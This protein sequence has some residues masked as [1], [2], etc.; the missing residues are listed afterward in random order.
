MTQRITLLCFTILMASIVSQAQ[1][2]KF[3]FSNIQSELLT[4]ANAVVRLDKT[5]IDQSNRQ[6]IICHKHFAITALNKAG[7][8]LLLFNESYKEG[9]DKI[10]DIKIKIYDATGALIRTIKKNEIKDLAAYDGFSMITDSRSKVFEIELSTFPVTMEWAFT[11][12]SKNTIGVEPW[13]PIL[14]Y[15]VSVEESTYKNTNTTNN[16]IE[17]NLSEYPTIT[18]GNGNYAAKNLT[19][20]KREPYSPAFSEFAPYVLFNP[21]EFIYEGYTGA[22]SSWEELGKWTYKNYLMDRNNL[23]A[24]EV[25]PDI[26]KIINGET[27]PE[28][29]AR[30]IY[31]YVQE[32]TRYINISLN[33]GGVRPMKSQDVH[34]KKYGDCKA[35]SFYMK[36]LL[37]LY[38]IEANY[39]EVYA[40][41]T[42]PKSLIPEFCSASQGNHII[43]NIP[44]QQDT[45][46]VD[47]TS[48]ELPFNFLGTFTDNRNALI[49]NENGGSLVKTPTY[50]EKNNKIKSIIKTLLDENGDIDAKIESNYTGIAMQKRLFLNNI[51][52]EEWD[53][54]L[55]E[56]L[57]SGQDNLEIKSKHHQLEETEFRINEIYTIQSTQ[58]GSKAGKYMI[59]PVEFNSFDIPALRKN[60]KRRLDVLIKRGSTQESKQIIDLPT[61]FSYTDQAIQESLNT[62]FGHYSID[63][64]LENN[65]LLIHRKLVIFQGQYSSELYS[66]IRNFFNSVLK[67]E[68][69]KISITQ[70]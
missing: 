62:D 15:G 30:I 47:C 19:A 26:D 7:S 40:S 56:N 38:D 45:A 3:S 14:T 37:H 29:I 66:E 57:F 11:R 6:K 53:K 36:S 48:S 46:W 9:S 49:I 8:Q 28:S 17:R 42:N 10:K 58:Y 51:D 41:H 20:L 54:K 31:N 22:F 61:G 52:E 5:T 18:G 68:Q 35:L 12:E 65:Q 39:V 67:L 59:L 34:S 13:T 4:H 43:L 70:L 1:L 55:K 32:N 24:N 27:D 2:S 21:R 63:V 33:E 23:N 69:L 16:Y 64:G 25:K 60:S 44:F 50:N